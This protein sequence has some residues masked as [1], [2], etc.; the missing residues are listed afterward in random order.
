MF[1]KAPRRVLVPSPEPHTRGHAGELFVPMYTI[2]HA[3][4]TGKGRRPVAS[5]H[6]SRFKIF[7]G[8]LGVAFSIT[9]V[10]FSLVVD[11][12][13]ENVFLVPTTQ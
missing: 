10:L 6:H 12:G 2:G 9:E 11:D 8:R 5:R 1:P 7:G 3:D 4:P 13:K